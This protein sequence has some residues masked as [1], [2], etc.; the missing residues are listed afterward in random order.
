M[1]A[2]RDN[3]VT[4]TLAEIFNITQYK[5]SRFAALCI[6]LLLNF[7]QTLLAGPNTFQ[8]GSDTIHNTFTFPTFDTFALAPDFAETPAVFI[9]GNIAGNNSCEVRLQNIDTDSFDAVCAEDSSWDGEHVDVPIQFA[10]ITEGVKTIPTNN[11][12]SVTFEVGCVDT[13]A[14][15]HNCASGCDAESYEAITFTAGFTNPPVVIANIQTVANATLG[16]PPSNP[17]QP[18]LSVAIDNIAAGGFDLAL[19]LNKENN[20]GSLN[21]EKICWLAVEETSRC[22]LAGTD[23]TLNF[24]SIGGPASVAFEAIITPDN[25]DGWD[26][27]CNN[28]EEATFTPGCFTSTPVAIA[29]KRGRQEAEGWLRYCT[30]NTGEL[31]LTI[32]EQR[33]AGQNRQHVDETASVIAFGSS[34]TTPVTLARFSSKQSGPRHA[35]FKWATES[36]SFNIGFNIWAEVDGE[37]VQVNRKMIVS[38]TDGLATGKSYKKK[39]KLGKRV[40]ENATA[41]GL[42]SYDNSGYE[43]FY[44]PFSL[45][46]TYGE[47]SK[48][49]PIDWADVRAKTNARM[50]QSGY[51]KLNGR[52]KR[53]NA[54]RAKYVNKHEYQ[55]NREVVDLTATESGVHRISYEDMIAAGSTWNNIPVD[56]LAITRKGEAVPRLIVSDNGV[57]DKGDQ[58]V[59]YASPLP[60]NDALYTTDNIYRLQRNKRKAVHA[61]RFVTE[62]NEGAVTS[63]NYLASYSIGDNKIY[64]PTST[65]GDPW[66]DQKI[67]SYGGAA[68]ASYQLQIDKPVLDKPGRL[69]VTLVGGID[70]PSVATENP[71][72]HVVLKVNGTQVADTRFDGFGDTTID[73]TLAPDML[74]Q[75]ENSIQVILPGD[76]GQLADIVYVDSLS[77]HAF[78]NS[79]LN[80]SNLIVPAQ[81]SINQYQIETQVSSSGVF[82]FAH[83]L[84]GNFGLIESATSDGQYLRFSGPPNLV[85]QE[86]RYSIISEDA[87]LSPTSLS[88]L[89]PIDLTKDLNADYLIV[90]HPFFINQDLERFA[91][92]KREQGL[93][94]AVVSWLD[95]VD[96]YGFGL[97]T[98]SALR[99]FLKAADKKSNSYEYVLIVGGHSYDYNDHLQ[100]GNVNFIPTMYQTVS[101]NF[102]YAPSDAL[103]VDINDNG[104]PNKSIGRWPVRSEQDL[105][106][107]VNKTLRWQTDGHLY[108]DNMLLLA[109]VS[110][111]ARGQNFSAQL[112]DVVSAANIDLSSPQ[113]TEIYLDNYLANDTDTPIEDARAD[114]FSQFESTSP[115]AGVTIFNGHSSSSRWTFRNLFSTQDVSLLENSDS[116]TFVLPLACY[117]TLYESP[118]VDTLAHQLLFE[119]ESGAVAL[120]GASYLS[121]YRENAAFAKRLLKKIKRPGFSVGQA[122]KTEKSKMM[123]W[124]DTVTN[125]SLLGDPSLSFSN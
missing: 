66:V 119:S 109:D 79:A 78:H 61:S 107:I 31:R 8:V 71:D 68:T 72:H 21:D 123:P 23:D 51:V 7:T 44:G 103:L 42:S 111:T 75:G 122:I 5:L 50:I 89:R 121:E 38:D 90:A 105:R 58:I 46:L 2:R 13:N 29:T 101:K 85:A 17:I 24:S 69:S 104:L 64:V 43:E 40:L 57:F 59:F 39:V 81:A 115:G 96:T 99:N 97:P 94:P 16:A 14:V 84:N 26:N 6:L 54:A 63:S 62:W 33:V 35:V 4:T 91:Q 53:S 74:V 98:P 125:W 100:L 56:Q 10:A 27:G 37:W 116:P 18:M 28:T 47:E 12:G 22:D 92:A 110:D 112:R 3:S 34:F 19:D 102:V 80:G 120:S 117:T 124:N 32:D 73:V 77:L 11:G 95:I 1:L 118:S 88:L 106:N 25:I 76:N 36:E 82:V 15:Q 86:T 52:W 41:Y 83:Q 70:F 55:L 20:V 67:F 9:L 49:K 114:L 30:L 87:F 60:A 108:Q 45:S 48:F 113:V 93:E 65:N